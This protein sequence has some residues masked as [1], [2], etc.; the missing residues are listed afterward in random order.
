MKAIVAILS[1]CLFLPLAVA[2][3]PLTPEVPLEHFES[4]FEERPERYLVDPQ[5][6]LGADDLAEREEFLSYHAGESRIDFHVLLFDLGQE[7]PNEIRIEELA[8]RFF[9]EGKP[10]L[11]ALYFLGEPERTLIQLSP[12]IRET[13]SAAELG[14][15]RDEA[16]R[17]ARQQAASAE[18]LEAF[19][20]QMAIRIFWIEREADLGPEKPD[21][22]PVSEPGER[23]L[24]EPKDEEPGFVAWLRR[25]WDEW[26]L[27]AAVILGGVL[28][29]WL[30]RAAVRRR[31]RY[32]FPEE[33][34]PDRL[35]G[36]RGAATG[37]VIDFSSSTRSP[38]EQHEGPGDSLGGL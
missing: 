32:V 29:A 3:E 5:G 37:E 27:P 7:I 30:V 9:G 23:T 38:S 20:K 24:A 13:V 4:Y 16:V 14:R 21:A 36:G 18:Q 17:A 25:C 33:A 19:C 11:L 28:S 6:L 34:V 26:G 10:S 15:V 2:Q 1:A 22:A 12:Q 8:E 35:G 31:A